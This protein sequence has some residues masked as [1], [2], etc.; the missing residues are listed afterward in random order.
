MYR[1]ARDKKAAIV[2]RL[3]IRSFLNRLGVACD[4]VLPVG[5]VHGKPYLQRTEGEKEELHIDFNLSHAGGWTVFVGCCCPRS[6]P[7]FAISCDVMPVE[8]RGRDQVR[9]ACPPVLLPQA[10]QG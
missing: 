10:T 7:A 2:G 5:R 3:L 1:F 9:L 4:G 6:S 8:I